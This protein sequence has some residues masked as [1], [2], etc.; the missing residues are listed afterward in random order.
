MW[1]VDFDRVRGR[2]RGKEQPALVVSSTFHLDSPM[3]SL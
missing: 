3:V 1:F 2:E